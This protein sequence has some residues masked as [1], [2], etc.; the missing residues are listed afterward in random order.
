MYIVY[1]CLHQAACVRADS[2]RIFAG[3]RFER[4]VLSCGAAALQ[5]C[6]LSAGKRTEAY[7]RD[8]NITET[9][10]HGNTRTH[11]QFAVVPLAQ[12]L[13]RVCARASAVSA[14]LIKA[15]TVQ[16]RGLRGE[17]KVFP[18]PPCSGGASDYR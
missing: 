16:S 5:S 3:P 7:P 1:I 9:R 17:I 2:C 8:A 10:V 15:D 6:R 18:P 13:V 12:L 11:T 14:G 4:W